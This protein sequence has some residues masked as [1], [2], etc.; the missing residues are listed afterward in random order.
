MMSRLVERTESLVSSVVCSG[1]SRGDE[2]VAN[3]CADFPRSGCCPIYRKTQ[4]TTGGSTT[5]IELVRQTP[6][7]AEMG[8]MDWADSMGNPCVFYGVDVGMSNLARGDEND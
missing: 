5:V 3:L 6:D 2:N 1:G 4:T 8:E 7:A